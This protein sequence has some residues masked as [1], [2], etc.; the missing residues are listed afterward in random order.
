MRDL[1]DR[2]NASSE[3]FH[4]ALADLPLT[5]EASLKQ[6]L[7]RRQLRRRSVGAALFLIVILWVCTRAGG[8]GG[9]WSA[10]QR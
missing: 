9:H 6:R 5:S 1:E 4:A 2:L 10:E 3:E 8:R 7:Q